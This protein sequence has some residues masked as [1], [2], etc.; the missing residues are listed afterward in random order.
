MS[1]NFRSI[2]LNTID[3][4]DIYW[5][6]SSDEKSDGKDTLIKIVGPVINSICIT[7][8]R[9]TTINYIENA[10]SIA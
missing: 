7:T 8:P 9:K 10:W 2:I 6:E 5:R 3:S 1:T 4:D